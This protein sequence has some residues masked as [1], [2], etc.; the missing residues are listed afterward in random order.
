MSRERD[1]E[2]EREGKGARNCGHSARKLSNHLMYILLIIDDSFSPS[3]KTV[4]FT[5]SIATTT[6]DVSC[7]AREKF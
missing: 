7:S 5:A 1:E 6:S 2:E 4:L 3:L